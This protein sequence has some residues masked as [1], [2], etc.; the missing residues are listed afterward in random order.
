MRP[1]DRVRYPGRSEGSCLIAEDRG[2]HLVAGTKAAGSPKPQERPRTRHDAPPPG[3]PPEPPRRARRRAVASPAQRGPTA[4]EADAGRRPQDWPGTELLRVA[5]PAAGLALALTVRASMSVAAVRPVGPVG[6]VWMERTGRAGAGGAIRSGGFRGPGR[7]LGMA[8][9]PASSSR[10]RSPGLAGGLIVP[11]QQQWLT[12]SAPCSAIA[13]SALAHRLAVALHSQYQ[14]AALQAA[15]SKI[16]RPAGCGSG[17]TRSAGTATGGIRLAIFNPMHMDRRHL[18]RGLRGDGDVRVGKPW[19]A[20]VGMGSPPGGSWF[21]TRSSTS[22]WQGVRSEQKHARSR[23]RRSRRI[24]ATTSAWSGWLIQV[25]NAFRAAILY[26]LAILEHP[27]L[28]SRGP[29]LPLAESVDAARRSTSPRTSHSSGDARGPGR[30]SPAARGRSRTRAG[31]SSSGSGPSPADGAA[32][33]SLRWSWLVN[34]SG[35]GNGNPPRAAV[36]DGVRPGVR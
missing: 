1:G 7:P 2:R 25:T 30:G 12:P 4:W 24:R 15:T 13:F 18:S 17:G 10:S 27:G 21:A 3:R 14:P 35:T 9:R 11:R 28:P 6:S 36:G 32:R 29:G 26:L 8:D 22:A 20:K 31:G 23:P 19:R 5:R 16:A 34:R 33:R